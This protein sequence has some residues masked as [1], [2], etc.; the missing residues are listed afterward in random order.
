MESAIGLDQTFA[1]ESVRDGRQWR[2]TLGHRRALVANSVGVLHLA[3]LLAAPR[4]EVRAL[5][6]VAGLA[7]VSRSHLVS[8]QPV[9]DQA[10]VR[11]Y[12]RRLREIRREIDD[13]G[14]DADPEKLAEHEWLLAELAAGTG[15]GGRTRTFTDDQERARIAVGKAIR[16]AIDRIGE[17]DPEIGRH[18]RRSVTTG[19]HCCYWPAEREGNSRP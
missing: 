11:S 10:A 15:I 2:I 5:D 12:L 16:R 1:A 8:A 3:T 13:A 4:Q 17:A 6:L 14:P 19:N 9:L 18:L 7:A